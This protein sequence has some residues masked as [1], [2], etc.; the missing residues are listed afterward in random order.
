MFTYK[1]STAKCDLGQ[2]DAWINEAINNI[3]RKRR[4]MEAPYRIVL[5]LRDDR[6]KILFVKD[7]G[8]TTSIMLGAWTIELSA[9]SAL[10]QLGVAEELIDK[11]LRALGV[12]HER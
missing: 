1:N 9:R 2:P 6:L 7:V 5:R 3:A 10:Y 4:L 12:N 11:E 8:P